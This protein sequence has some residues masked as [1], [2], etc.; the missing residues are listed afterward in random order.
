VPCRQ[1]RTLDVLLFSPYKRY[2]SLSSIFPLL[3][4]FHSCPHKGAGKHY[5][6]ESW[7][8]RIISRESA[9]WAISSDR[10]ASD[11]GDVIGATNFPKS[12]SSF[13]SVCFTRWTDLFLLVSGRWASKE[14][15]E[16]RLY[17]GTK[18]AA[19]GRSPSFS[20]V[21]PAFGGAVEKLLLATGW[22]GTSV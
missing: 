17:F 11:F 20:K 3:W 22:Q 10:N 16:L 19:S 15:L 4:V 18:V 21:I 8:R 7:T 13:G 6:L 2:W 1:R 12:L 5:Q 9:V 14:R